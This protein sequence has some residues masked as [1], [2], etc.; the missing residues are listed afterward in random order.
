MKKVLLTST[1]L[2]MTA[3]VAAAEMSMSASAT[4]TYGN[5]GTG[6]TALDSAAAGGTVPDA[7][8]SSEAALTASGS[9]G[10]G[11]LSYSG[12]IEIEQGNSVAV[13]P[14]SVST[15]GLT[16]VY[17]ENELGG[18]ATTATAADATSGD[19]GGTAVAADVDGEDNTHGDY[20]I[21]YSAGG[22][23]ASYTV[24][25]DTDDT[26]MVLGYTSGALTIGLSMLD[27][28]D[29]LAGAAACDITETSVGY[30]MGDATV[31]LSA[32]DNDDW[33]ASVAYVSGSTTL[34]VATDE[35]NMYSAGLSYAAGDMTFSA[36]QEFNN[37]AGTVD[38]TEFGLSYTAGDMTFSANYDSG[39]ENHYGDE[40]MTVIRASY[41]MDGM[42]FS[43]AATDQDEVELS[44]SF[45][46]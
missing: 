39:Q 28:C 46:F 25:N 34:T 10:G 32:D 26:E 41:A 18:I 16:F 5:F 14:F 9:G 45:S 31:T 4:L 43:G 22:I 20:Q 7:S 19:A 37:P 11:T 2:V 40:A 13:G 29:N 3:G 36:R 42:T 6:L 17:D 44:M 15:G 8:W 12:S 33:D 24:D 30:V 27:E 21:S 23:S 38:E 1:A 35:T